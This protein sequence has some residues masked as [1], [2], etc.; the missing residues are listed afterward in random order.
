[1]FYSFYARSFIFHFCLSLQL[2]GIHCNPYTIVTLVQI[3]LSYLFINGRKNKVSFLQSAFFLLLTF[4]TVPQIRACGTNKYC[5]RVG[6]TTKSGFS[7]YDKFLILIYSRI[8]QR[9]LLYQN[10]Q[11]DCY[12][13]AMATLSSPEKDLL[14]AG[15]PTSFLPG[16][17]FFTFFFHPKNDA[18]CFIQR[19]YLRM[20]NLPLFL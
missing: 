18:S 17:L 13:F 8:S 14:G 5:F 1:M 11:N 6:Y 12:R 9:A 2:C 10:I 19:N 15:T 3:N 7:F 20:I 16:Y 4:G